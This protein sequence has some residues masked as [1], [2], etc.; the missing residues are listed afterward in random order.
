M[1]VPQEPQEVPQKPLEVPQTPQEIPQKPL[2]VP[3]NPQEIPQRVWEKVTV[4]QA[5]RMRLNGETKAQMDWA[6]WQKKNGLQDTSV[7]QPWEIEPTLAGNDKYVKCCSALY[8]IPKVVF[9]GPLVWMSLLPWMILLRIYGHYMTQGADP[10]DRSKFG[11]KF[12]VLFFGHI[13][14]LFP[15]AGMFALLMM[16]FAMYYVFSVPFSCC[17]ASRA[18][19]NKKAS[20]EAIDPFRKGPGWVWSDIFVCAIGQMNRNGLC[21]FMKTFTMMILVMPWLKYFVNANPWIYPLEIRYVQQISTTLEDC[22][23][24]QTLWAARRIICRSK[25]MNDVARRVDKWRFVPHYP[26]PPPGRRWAHGL[27]HAIFNLVT[28]VTHACVEEQGSTEQFVLANGVISP[29]WRVMLWYNNPY[30][31][32]TGFVEA[33]ISSGE[34]S[35]LDKRFGGEHPMWIVSS[36]S[37]FLSDRHSETGVGMI[38]HFF[39]TWLPFFV[40][41]VR[42][43]VRGLEVAKAMHMEVISKDGISRPAGKY[44]RVSISD[45]QPKQV[46]AMDTE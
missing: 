6:L 12:W 24:E 20:H 36:R 44:K 45:L 40:D 31:F 11:F 29:V 35:Q 16:D 28:H 34:P 5:T 1:E 17:K 26:Y 8:L 30:H 18:K 38:D 14:F 21:E 43:L 22:G 4:D 33:S 25:Q 13:L 42:T 10:C 37:F 27:Q 46:D 3:Q 41:E 15:R 19:Q 7:D 23:L 32:F 2:E 9:F 39:D